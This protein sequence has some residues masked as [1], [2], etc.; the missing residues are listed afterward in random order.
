M[1]VGGV[2]CLGICDGA[3]LSGLGLGLGLGLYEN[4]LK[5]VGGR[6]TVATSFRSRSARA[7]SNW[8]RKMQ[9]V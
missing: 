1:P 9:S 8:V 3:G 5:S 2:S 7:L 6:Q 4:A